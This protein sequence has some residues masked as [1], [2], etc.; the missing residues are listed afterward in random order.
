MHTVRLSASGAYAPIVTADRNAAAEA[1]LRIEQ[2]TYRGDVPRAAR[3]VR[4]MPRSGPGPQQ[5]AT[6]PH[7]FAHADHSYGNRAPSMT[8]SMVQV[9]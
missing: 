2:T 7:E 6:N 4:E 8:R 5:Q 9:G 3:E 1:R